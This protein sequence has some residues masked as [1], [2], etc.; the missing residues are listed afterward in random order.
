MDHETKRFMY[1][2]TPIY[3]LFVLFLIK[4]QRAFTLKKNIGNKTKSNKYVY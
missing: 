2:F 4:Q 1:C 3:I